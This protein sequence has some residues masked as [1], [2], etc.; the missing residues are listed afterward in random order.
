[1]EAVIR[2]DGPKP[3]T[4]GGSQSRRPAK[5]RREEGFVEG[6]ETNPACRGE[7]SRMRGS[8][9]GRLAGVAVGGSPIS[10]PG[11]CVRPWQACGTGRRIRD[12]GEPLAGDAGKECFLRLN[13]MGRMGKIPR[14]QVQQKPGHRPERWRERIS[15]G[16]PA[17]CSERGRFLHRTWHAWHMAA[18]VH[19]R[20]VAATSHP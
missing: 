9:R 17:L 1:M 3:V 20:P 19:V 2:D 12:G 8:R 4:A 5:V 16:T 18:S 6:E 7:A 13:P 10:G 14:R 11:G 15:S